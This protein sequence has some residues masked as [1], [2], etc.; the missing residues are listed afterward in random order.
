MRKR[1]AFLLLAVLFVLL[2]AAPVFAAAVPEKAGIVTD[3]AGIFASGELR[4]IE[5]RIGGRAY[6]V[7][8]L[9]A[10]GLTEEEGFRLANDAYDA[11]GLGAGDL[12]LVVTV[13]PNYAH[14]VYENPPLDSMVARSDA[15]SAKG[16]VDLAFVPLARE[17]RVAEGV[18]AV[19]DYINR[20]GAGGAAVPGL[21]EPERPPGA[22]YG[23]TAGGTLAGTIGFAVALVVLIGAILLFVRFRTA[24]AAR[25]RLAEA[26]KL[27]ADADRAVSGALVSE[28]FRELESGFLQGRSKAQAEEV[29]QEALRLHEAAEALKGRLEAHKVPVLAGT[30]ARRA[31]EALRGEAEELGRQSAGV[32]ERIAAIERQFAE[33]RRTVGALKKRADE[34]AAGIEALAAE[35]GHP[36]GALRRGLEQAR[37]KL[38]EADRL[39]EFDIAGAAGPA[40]EAGQALD[41]VAADTA[42]LRKLAAVRHEWMP[43]LQEKEAELRRTVEREGL[44]LPEEDPFA[45]LASAAAEAGRLDRLLREGRAPEARAAAAGIEASLARAESI[46]TAAIRGRDESEGVV[47]EAE[48]VLGEAPAFEAAYREELARLRA[49]YADTHVREQEDRHAGLGRLGE[50]LARA[51]ADI[52]AALDPAAQRYRFAGERSG[53]AAAMMADIRRLRGESLAYRGEL[54]AR[55]RAAA[56]RLQAAQ[57]R[58]GDAAAALQRLGGA[59]ADA[60]LRELA[61]DAER[62]GRAAQA[63]L[64]ARPADLRAA[65]E[66]LAAFERAADTLAQRAEELARAREEALRA[67]AQLQEQFAARWTRYGGQLPNGATYAAAMRNVLAAAESQAVAG[68]FADAAAHVEQGHGLLRQMDDDYRRMTAA[69]ASRRTYRGGG[70]FGGGGFG[71]GG[72]GI[73]PRGGGRSGGSSG[74]GGGGGRRGGGGGRSGG[75]SKW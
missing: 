26:R 20:L 33:V 12:V 25:E 5:D 22:A 15:G 41:E 73:P 30:S 69:A 38:A 18:I 34:A 23:E 55:L 61:A 46:V 65:E 54:D 9:T 60:G 32:A 1:V 11:W 49:D 24:A 7:H 66:R 6:D 14:L 21:P 13:D 72:F 62:G 75:S 3:A 74:W 29:Q 43:R 52:R 63:A 42:D 35:T 27:L 56:G 45:V 39:D 70:G 17:G 51:A 37:G 44:L 71:G 4:A 8:V 57:R 16:V 47:R 36:L 19:S 58:M 67:M 59:A 50:E 53:Q 2:T 40:A 31:A 28:F 64:A 68:R 48:R 10:S